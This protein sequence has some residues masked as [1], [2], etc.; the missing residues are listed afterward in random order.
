MSGCCSFK[1][2][3]PHEF[4]ARKDL[5]VL[6]IKAPDAVDEFQT[7]KNVISA[8]TLSEAMGELGQLPM[9]QPIGVVCQDGSCSARSAIRLSASGRPIFHLSGGLYEWHYRVHNAS[10]SA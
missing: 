2:L 1:E 5:V 4:D 8:V 9:D 10:M 7:F 6:L 3:S